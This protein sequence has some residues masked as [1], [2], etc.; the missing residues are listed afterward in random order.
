MVAFDVKLSLST[1]DT[2]GLNPANHDGTT[3]H[4]SW[5]K[6]GKSVIKNGEMIGVS[7]DFWN[8]YESDIQLAKDLGEFAEAILDAKLQ[9]QTT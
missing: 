7:S 9:S 8:N 4:S 3:A 2:S 6:L 5:K 1:G